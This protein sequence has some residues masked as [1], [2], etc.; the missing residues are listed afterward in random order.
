M[1]NGQFIVNKV[2][3]QRAFG[4]DSGTE[5]IDLDTSNYL[6]GFNL[7]VHNVNGSTSNTSGTIE[8]GI[9]RLEVTADGVVI[10]SMTGLMARKI[11][12]FDIGH[13][14]PYDEIQAGSAT[15]FAVFPVKFG[16]D[17]NDKDIILPAHLFTTLQL[18][19][20][21]AFTDSTTTGWTTS[22][23]NAKYDLITRSLIGNKLVNTPFLKKAEGF[24]KTLNTVQEE[25]INLAVGSGAGAYRRIFLYAREAS[26]GD[27]VDIDKFE[28]IANDSQRLVNERWDTSQLEDDMRYKANNN[29]HVTAYLA[30]NDTY[31]CRVTRIRAVQGTSQ[32]D[33]DAIATFNHAV[34][35]D[36]SLTIGLID[37]AGTAV[38]QADEIDISIFAQ[39]VSN[40]T[41]IDLGTDDINDS[42]D[43][44][45]DS[46]VSS[47]KVRLNVAAAGALTKMVSEQ[48]V[49][50]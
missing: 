27:G 44:G 12:Q 42:L 6:Q 9:T 31:N 21:Y 33:D 50:F 29:K 22:E 23:S 5:T 11:E 4:A 14:A 35:T 39:G 2:R 8:S 43:V 7:R 10:Y 16:R 13:L 18:K 3:E 30:D 15:Q 45:H 37:D 47:L 38:T 26:I 24:S 28:L 46:G 41:V 48:V 49:V 1:P 34:A 17:R 20:T 19:I 40:A 25:D 36:D 32:D